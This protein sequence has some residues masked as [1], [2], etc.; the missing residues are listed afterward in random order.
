MTTGRPPG[1]ALRLVLA[2]ELLAIF[3][4]GGELQPPDVLPDEDVTSL[5]R[6]EPTEEVV[7][8]PL[9]GTLEEH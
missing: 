7:P 9:P 5:Q 3:G 4:L 8:F 2:H 1:Q 6:D